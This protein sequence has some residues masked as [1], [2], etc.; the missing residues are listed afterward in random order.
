MPVV[1]PLEVPLVGLEVSGRG[2]HHAAEGHLEPLG[3]R[4]GNLVLHLEDVFHLPVVA[5]RPDLE[6]VSGV[7]ELHGVTNPVGGAPHASLEY[8]AYVQTGRTHRSRRLCP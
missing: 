5:L 4:R 6:A 1:A 7:H 3:D 2:F 8:V